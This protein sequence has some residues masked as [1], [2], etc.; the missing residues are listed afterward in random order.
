MIARSA[1]QDSKMT[2]DLSAVVVAVAEDEPEGPDL[3]D[4]Q[5]GDE[6]A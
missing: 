1:A 4:T 5:P 3:S 2:I 6:E